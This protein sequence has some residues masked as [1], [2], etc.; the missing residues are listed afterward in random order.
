MWLTAHSN[1]VL[2]T[3]NYHAQRGTVEQ[4]TE[5][6]QRTGCCQEHVQTSYSSVVIVTSTTIHLKFL[7]RILQLLLLFVVSVTIY[8]YMSDFSILLLRTMSVLNRLQWKYIHT[9]SMAITKM[10]Y[11][12]FY[13]LQTH[14][15][16]HKIIPI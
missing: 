4:T 5:E 8:Y 10:G 7:I 16:S 6:Q 3:Y 14:Q 11:S 12:V 2:A 15:S 1:S 13:L 9:Q